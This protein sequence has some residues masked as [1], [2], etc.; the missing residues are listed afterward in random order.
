MVQWLVDGIATRQVPVDDRG[1]AYGDGLFE[2]I[3][4]REGRPRFIDRHLERLA[5]GAERLGLVQPGLAPLERELSDLAAGLDWG[6]AKI[7]L[8]RGSGPRGYAPPLATAV[9]R[10][11]GVFPGQRPDTGPY[12]QGVRLRYC[13]TPLAENPVL[14]GL[15][16]LNRL[17]QV[18]ARAEW[19]QSGIA[20]GLMCTPTGRVVCGTMTNVF[21][22]IDE[23]LVTP[24]L[25]TCGIAGVMRGLVLE[26][27]AE[28]GDPV[29]TRDLSPEHLEQASE[30]FLTNS[31]IGLWPARSIEATVYP[32]G[33]V[34]RR[35]MNGL[36][37]R[38]VSECAG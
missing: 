6:S 11:V 17:E 13:R 22:V 12:R 38:G 25:Q 32:I 9:R 34:T 7:I 4:I 35:L 15:K 37:A 36:A 8:T 29:Q 1:L 14:A 24:G 20:E 27:A 3:A 19:N 5:H 30:V 33:P 28:Q 10:M 2:T 21:A 31:Q 23:R 16:T 26:I 18:L